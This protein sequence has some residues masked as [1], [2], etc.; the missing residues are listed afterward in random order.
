MSVWGVRCQGG[1]DPAPVVPLSEPLPSIGYFAD[2]LQVR[3]FR[4]HRAD[5]LQKGRE[6]LYYE[7]TYG[8]HVG[9]LLLE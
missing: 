1:P 8:R 9:V 3:P 5:N 2:D 6:I 4:Q 7:Y